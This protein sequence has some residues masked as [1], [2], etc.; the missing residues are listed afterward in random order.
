[1]TGTKKQP[2]EPRTSARDKAGIMP[3][4]VGKVFT[5]EANKKQKREKKSSMK[6][7]IGDGSKK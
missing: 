3:T 4:E 2:A 7:D 6:P 5:P 1:M